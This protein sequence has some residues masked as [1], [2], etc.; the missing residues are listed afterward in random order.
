MLKLFYH[1]H[2]TGD[3]YADMF[4]VDE[5]LKRLWYS[6]LM[7]NAACYAVICGPNPNLIYETIDRTRRI[8]I[9]EMMDNDMEQLFEGRTLRHIKNEIND[10]DAVI[11]MHTKGISYI[12]GNRTV[13]GI[14][15]A[16]HAKAINGWRDTMEHHILDCW[17]DR[18]IGLAYYDTQGCYLRDDPFSHYMGNFWWA[19]GSY[20]LGLPDV[21]NFE[22]KPYPG[23]EFE[24]TKP[25]RMR[26]EQWLLL[27]PGSHHSIV[28][29]P[30]DAAKQQPGYSK[31]FTPYEDDVSLL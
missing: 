1:V 30:K 4:F 13:N 28:P 26:Y 9:L 15:S 14:Y 6:G 21:F 25:S 8:R 27:N 17:R 19:R 10:G 3:P 18:N 11:Y 2:V 12:V 16:R 5:Q 29:Y 22:V 23:M 20:V 7:E 24:E 31:D